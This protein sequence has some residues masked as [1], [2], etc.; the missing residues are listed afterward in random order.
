MSRRWQVIRWRRWALHQTHGRGRHQILTSGRSTAYHSALCHAVKHPLFIRRNPIKLSTFTCKASA[1]RGGE[2]GSLLILT[3]TGDGDSGALG[4]RWLPEL[5]TVRWDKLLPNSSWRSLVAGR[6]FH[7]HQKS[8]NVARILINGRHIPKFLG[9]TFR[10]RDHLNKPK[11][12][13]FNF[14]LWSGK[15]C[16]FKFFSKRWKGKKCGHCGPAVINQRQNLFFVSKKTRSKTK[17]EIR[18]VKMCCGRSERSA[19]C[20]APDN[21]MKLMWRELSILEC[22]HLTARNSQ[23]FPSRSTDGGSRYSTDPAG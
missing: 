22:G 2:I 15:T 16:F 5:G 20:G 18:I 21:G 13:F 11:K 12:K 7:K 9:G 4:G 17:N 23:P 10:S 14:P 8:A 3:A 1:S 19:Q 6:V